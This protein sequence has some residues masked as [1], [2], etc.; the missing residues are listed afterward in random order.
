MKL[1]GL[2][3][4]LLAFG[5]S[6]AIAQPQTVRLRGTITAVDGN[7]VILTTRKGDTVRIALTP[8]WA[9]TAISPLT[10]ADIKQNSFVG[11]GS[12]PQPDG[13]LKAIEVVVF[14]EAARGLGEGHRGWDFL[15]ESTMTNA[16]VTGVIKGNDGDTL[17]LTYK[18]GSKTVIVAKDVPI[19]TFGPG[20]RALA[21]PGAKVIVFGAV[22][23]PDG[24]FVAK[25]MFIGKDGMTPPM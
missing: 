6:S 5:A 1:F 18:D 11:I 2:L 22:P 3:F 21:T 7:T 4:A 17:T 8:E 14:P 9:A 12:L 23:Q 13:T 15:P 20:D 19:V 25:G 16:T 24:S 10:M